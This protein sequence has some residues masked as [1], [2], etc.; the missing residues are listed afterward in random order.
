MLTR[1]EH[2]LLF[3]GWLINIDNGELAYSYVLKEGFLIR[4]YAKEQTDPNRLK[5][6]QVEITRYQEFLKDLM[7]M[8]LALEMYGKSRVISMRRS[9]VI[10]AGW[11][12]NVANGEVAIIFPSGREL[13]A[14]LYLK[15]QNDSMLL[16]FDECVIGRN[17]AFTHDLVHINVLLYY[18]NQ[19]LIK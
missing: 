13:I 17:S 5:A 1:R 8:S 14:R 2:E 16:V 6:D 18:I 9:Q 12:I 7:P 15:Q 10:Q 11:N 19:G 3:P 4:V